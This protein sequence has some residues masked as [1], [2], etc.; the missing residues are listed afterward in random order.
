MPDNEIDKNVAYVAFGSDM[1]EG[2]AALNSAISGYQII[3]KSYGGFYQDLSDL[4][5]NVSGRPG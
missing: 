3:H 4:A 2:V 5:T 1:K